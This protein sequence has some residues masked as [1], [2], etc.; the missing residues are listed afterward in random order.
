MRFSGTLRNRAA[1]ALALALLVSVLVAGCDTVTGKTET[2]TG[3]KV[4]V[5]ADL[6]AGV[7]AYNEGDFSDA[8]SALADVVATDPE[9]TEARKSLALA[10]SAQGK[11]DEA[12]EQYLAV[13]EIEP[14]DHVVLYRLALIERPT[15]L[16][17]DAVGHLEKAVEL[18]PDDSYVDELARTYMQLKEYQK[19]ADTWGSLTAVESRAPESAVALLK[20]QAEALRL[21]GDIDGARTAL[22]Q[23]LEL[24]PEDA[25]LKAQLEALGE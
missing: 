13:L 4:D 15:G 6:Q 2:S 12:I 20:L 3:S 17:D 5:S 1:G 9:N 16:L 14:D 21:A 8:E 22:T 24:A 10:L 11:N 7:D 23:A 25:D 19:A 18:N